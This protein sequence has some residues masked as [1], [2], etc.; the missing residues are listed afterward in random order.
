M[1]SK[2]T[3]NAWQICKICIGAFGLQFG[4]ALPQANATRIFQN[5]GASLDTVPLLML[6][7]PITGLIV[8]PLVGY[9][10]DRTWTAFGRRRPYFLTGAAFAAGALIAMPNTTMLWTA[11]LMLWLLDA[12]VNFTMGPYRAFVADQ[13]P[14]EQ[15]ATG[16]LMY[17]FFASVGA[18]VGSL[19][20]WGMTHL[21]LSPAAPSGAISESVKVAFAV[22][23][24]LLVAALCASAFTHRE[25]RPDELAAFDDDPGERT[26]E[27][28]ND[29]MRRHAIAWIA[30]GLTGWLTAW[31][32][33]ARL[34][35]Y[36]LVVAAIAYGVSLLAASA[37]RSRNAFTSI[38]DDLESMSG[39]MRWLALVQFFSW[40]SLFTIFAYTI[41][42]VAKLHFHATTPGSPAYEAAANWVGVLFATYNG[43]GAVTALILPLFVKRLGMRRTHQLNLWIGAAGLLSMLAIR[44]PD[45]LLLSMVGLGFAWASIIALPYAMLANN[46]PARKMGVNMGIFNIFIVIPQL[47]AAG[48]LSWLLDTVAGGDP[49]YT[50]GIAAAG[51]ILAGLAVFRVRDSA[52]A[53]AAPRS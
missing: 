50:F 5:L 49:V 36:V 12:S 39:S 26:G 46:L 13:M 8:Q 17:M 3:L 10:S 29:R 7:G 53:P 48:M 37:I 19:L 1:V 28:S 15:R 45:W 41:P 6:A 51:W 23:A 9:Y 47:L 18:V 31:H 24:V 42:A 2:P 25:F 32:F 21:G 33:A 14:G 44:N 38:I 16:Y 22:G 35:L 11:M 40:F 20:P 43:L 27:R 4:F 30:I 34:A 52:P